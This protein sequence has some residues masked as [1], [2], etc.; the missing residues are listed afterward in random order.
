[1]IFETLISVY[2]C[3]LLEDELHM[4]ALPCNID[5]LSRVKL[6]ISV[7]STRKLILNS[8]HHNW[9]LSKASSEANATESESA[10]LHSGLVDAIVGK[11]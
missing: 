9:L 5:I 4:L 6:Y 10:M 3:F 2:L 11:I 7:I 8:Y 1:M